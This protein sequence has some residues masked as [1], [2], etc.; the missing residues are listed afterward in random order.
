MLQIGIC[1]DDKHMLNYLSDLCARILP[2]S[3][4]HVYTSGPKLLE[5]TEDFDILLMD[6]RMGDMDV[7]EVVKQ[8]RSQSVPKH[9][10]AVIF[11]TAYDDM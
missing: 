5:R 3:R 11:I 8:L 1:D 2:D 9:S 4:I 6:V 7:L 10:P